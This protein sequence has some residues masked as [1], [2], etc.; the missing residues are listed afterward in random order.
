MLQLSQFL[1]RFNDKPQINSKVIGFIGSFDDLPLLTLSQIGNKLAQTYNIEL[2]KL[3]IIEQNF[4]EWQ[5]Q[6]N[7]SFLGLSRVYWLTGTEDIKNLT[8]VLNLLDQYDGPH[9][10]FF[11][12][13]RE[14]IEKIVAKNIVFVD[15]PTI[16]D[17][18]SYSIVA[19]S[20]YQL[21]STESYATELFSRV[22]KISV[23]QSC[24]ILNYL[25]LTGTFSS[26]L[27]T[28]DWFE[29]IITP[30][31]SL[32]LLSQYFFAKDEKNFFKVWQ[33]IKE[34]YSDMFWLSFWSEQMWRAYYVTL[35]HQ[36]KSPI[37]L[38]KMSFRLPFSFI[39]KQCKEY[40]I[41]E[42]KKAHDF[43]YNLDFSL[44]NGTTQSTIEIFYLSFF[45]DSFQ[46]S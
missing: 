16:I 40:S 12:I 26:D 27:L 28:S 44:K 45:S 19:N 20:L 6:I 15:L 9:Y 30:E 41:A 31:R 21:S 34:D 18:K 42:L 46:I 13:S 36:K 5:S 3:E 33:L 10:L 38:K 35:F 2:K 1:E 29:K 25:E 7:S 11:Y 23:E 43:L 8:H 17:K 4:F 14:Q 39:Q 24:L 32:F 37:A 22:E